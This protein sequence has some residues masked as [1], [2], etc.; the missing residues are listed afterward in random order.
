[1]K[2]TR[3]G[4]V[5]SFPAAGAA[6]ASMAHRGLECADCRLIMGVSR[7]TM[8]CLGLGGKGP[9]GHRLDDGQRQQARV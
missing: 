5:L 6:R 9:D 3:P 4:R 1:M 7:R 8:E 2:Q